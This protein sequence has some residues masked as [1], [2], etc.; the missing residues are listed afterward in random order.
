MSHIKY[1][2]KNENGR[3]FIVGDIHGCYD[4]L[5][6]AIG[7]HNFDRSID[8]L[9]SVGDLVDRGPDSFKCLELVFEPWFY[10]VRGNHEMLMMDG[11]TKPYSLDNWLING[12][13]WVYSEDHNTVKVIAE[14]ALERMS[15]AIELDIDGHK[16]GIVH[17]EVCGGDW[18]TMRSGTFNEMNVIW[19]RKRI[20]NRIVT[21]IKNI[22]TV[23][24]GHSIVDNPEWLGNQYYIDTGSFHTGNI[25]VID[26]MELTR[27]R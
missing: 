4:K 22:D 21:P 23:V 26:A 27:G 11:L 1:F 2:T 8:R 5:M 18:E 13:A 6:V 24:C 10:A 9:F 20:N 12:G 3:D 17:G 7:E 15:Y 19:G 16:I 25:T 14:A